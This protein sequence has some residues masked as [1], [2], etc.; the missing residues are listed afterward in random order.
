MTR[1]VKR[2]S[3]NLRC[4]AANYSGPNERVIEFSGAKSGGLISITEDSAGVLFVNVYR[5]NGV[6]VIS[7]EAGK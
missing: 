1:K 6:Q 3:V 5:C 2:P 7:K 4:V